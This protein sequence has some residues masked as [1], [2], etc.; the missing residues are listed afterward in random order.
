MVKILVVEDDKALN[1][2]LCSYL[3]ANGY[4]ARACFDG[5]EGMRAFEEGGFSLVVSDI[6]MPK[7][8]GFELAENIRAS[9]KTLPILFTTAKDDKPSKLYGYRLGVDDYVTKPYDMDVLVLKIAALLRRAK[10]ESEKAVEIGNFRMDQEERTALLNGEEIALTAR[11]FDILFKFLSY[12]KK[13]FTRS[14]LMEEFWDYDSSA[15]SRTVD[16]YV[17]KIREKTSACDGFEIV[18]VHGLGYKAVLK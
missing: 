6:M 7:M 18:T 8:D 14:A 5:E 11:E 4:E 12:P 3:K 13:T 10:I 9:D 1:G 2:L 16:V 17:A 15:T